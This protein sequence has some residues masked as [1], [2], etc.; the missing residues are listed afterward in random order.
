M[1]GYLYD[2]L[3]PNLCV[4]CNSNLH[5]PSRP[6]CSTCGYKLTPTDFHLT[7]E[8][9][10]QARFWGRVELE[11]V[12]TLWVFQKAG[13]AQKLIHQLKYKNRPDIGIEVGKYYAGLLLSNPIF[14]TIDIIIPVPMHKQKE[15]E[16]GYNQAAKFAQGLAEVL[17]KP[18]CDSAFIKE[19]HTSTQTKKSRLERFE[20]IAHAFKVI[21]KEKLAHKHILLVDDVLTTGATLEACAIEI[22]NLSGCKVS[23]ACIALSS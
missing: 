17:K 8:N 9:A 6:W 5:P 4:A 3:Y 21:D 15:F 10:A 18:W 14:E 20:N 19:V 1:L 23:I 16:R 12:C 13:L 2:L 22:L 7:K 11:Q